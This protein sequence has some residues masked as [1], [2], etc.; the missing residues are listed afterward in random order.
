MDCSQTCPHVTPRCIQRTT[1]LCMKRDHGN[2]TLLFTCI[3]VNAAPYLSQ[4]VDC[5][6]HVPGQGY[7]TTWP[8]IING[9][10]PVVAMRGS[11]LSHLLLLSTGWN[12]DG[13]AQFLHQ[14]RLRQGVL[15][16]VIGSL[17][18][19][20][21]QSRHSPSWHALHAVTRF[22]RSTCT[23]LQSPPPTLCLTTARTIRKL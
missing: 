15:A 6:V 18:L 9:S 17:F 3:K 7:A 23:V 12:T 13:V 1:Q 19:L 22:L 20:R 2:I 4:T 5:R 16:A 14:R 21:T 11:C 8:P 10:D